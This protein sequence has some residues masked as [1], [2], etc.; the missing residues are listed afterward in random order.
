MPALRCS[1]QRRPIDFL[2]VVFGSGAQ[3]GDSAARPDHGR[4]QRHRRPDHLR[5]CGVERERRTV[6]VCWRPGSVRMR[7]N[8]TLGLLAAVPAASAE[9]SVADGFWIAMTRCPPWL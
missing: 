4:R 7:R 1:L 5:A 6:W 3:L 8:R 2:H 9:P